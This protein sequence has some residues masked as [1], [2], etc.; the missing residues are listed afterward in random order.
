VL[1]LKGHSQGGLAEASGLTP[2]AISFLE[3]GLTNPQLKTLYRVANALECSVRYLICGADPEQRIEFEGIV[4]RV[5]E[6][7]NSHDAEATR[8]LFSG[9]AASQIIM[10]RGSMSIRRAPD[11]ERNSGSVASSQ[12]GRVV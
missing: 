9:L 1:A 7:L 10:E 11:A 6:V 8:A 12:S 3:N 2:A 5:I 4:G